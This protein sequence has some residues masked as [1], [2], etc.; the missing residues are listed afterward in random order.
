MHEIG[1]IVGNH[2]L[3][4]FVWCRAQSTIINVVEAL[5]LVLVRYIKAILVV[6]GPVVW[7][8]FGLIG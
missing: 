8:R 1:I 3:N 4:V 6:M 5:Q 2:L 7:P